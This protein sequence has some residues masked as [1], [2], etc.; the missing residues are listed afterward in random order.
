MDYILQ[1]ELSDALINNE[2]LLWVGK[3]KKGITLRST[4]IFL[5]P[6]SLL[7]CGFAIF[8]EY[9]VLKM[10]VS[11]MAL[12]GIPFVLI[13]LYMVFGR[14]IVDA[15]KRKKTVYGITNDRVIIKSGLFKT[16]VS[17]IN[18]KNLPQLNLLEHKNGQGSVLFTEQNTRN[19]FEVNRNLN[20]STGAN[21]GIEFVDDAK[22]VYGLL[23][24]LQNEGNTNS[25]FPSL[26]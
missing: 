19:L 7:W 12:F 15:I 25:K 22:K 4:D 3:P 20:F 26:L 21:I 2:R 13:G 8:W 10:G 11:F 23:I 1:Q 18:I 24:Q 5:I 17:S 9:S 16:S 14:F 6:F